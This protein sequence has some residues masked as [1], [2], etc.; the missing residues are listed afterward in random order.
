M[1]TLGDSRPAYLQVAD[2]LRAE[3]TGG[4]L[5][6]GERLPSVRDLSTRFEIAATTTQSALRVLRQEGFVVS[7]S[8]RGYYVRDELPEAPAPSAEYEVIRDQL[9]AVQSAVDRLTERVNRLEEAAGRP[10]RRPG[11]RSPREP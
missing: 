4:R 8:T 3:I 5:Q 1:T 7:R 6:P 11:Q 10:D 9:G 2:E